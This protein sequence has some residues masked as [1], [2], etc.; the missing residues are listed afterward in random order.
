MVNVFCGE[1]A[2]C[3]GC[4]NQE[5]KSN[6]RIIAAENPY[7]FNLSSGQF[8]EVETKTAGALIQFLQA[9]IPPAAGFAVAFLIVKFGFPS[10]GEGMRAAAG[11]FGLFIAGFA[12]FLY[13]KKVPVKNNPRI[14][15]ILDSS[16]D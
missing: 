3:F 5:C 10:S 4:M 2:A 1:I 9:I 8:V 6:K 13:R 16:G 14:V 11:I 12:V 15:R 7:H